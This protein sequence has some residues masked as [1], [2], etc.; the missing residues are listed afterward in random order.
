MNRALWV[1]QG[2]LAVVFLFSGA[3]KLITPPEVMAAQMALPLP[4]WFITFIGVCEVLGGLG[5]V[6]PGLL[7]IRTELT[8]LAA[9]GLT[10]IMV[11]AV[12]T[13]LLGGLGFAMA[14]LPLVVLLL[15]AFVAYGRTRLAPLADGPRRGAIQPAG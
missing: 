4:I 11:G 7:R 2:L 13:T 15:V 12:V 14:A 3:M 10:V 1:V 6:L 9:T 5:L 8:A